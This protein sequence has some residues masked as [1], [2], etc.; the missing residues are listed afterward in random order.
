MSSIVCEARRG[1]IGAVALLRGSTTACATTGARCMLRRRITLRGGQL[2]EMRG[3]APRNPERE[4]CTTLAPSCML[5][6]STFYKQIVAE[7][8]VER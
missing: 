1:L 4:L 8:E 3:K 5:S 7:L 2:G 6:M